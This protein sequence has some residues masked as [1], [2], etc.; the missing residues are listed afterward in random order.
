[1]DDDVILAK[2]Q[3]LLDS[4]S[5]R[6]AHLLIQPLLKASQPDALFLYST[7]SVD[8]NE[9]NEEFERRSIAL[10]TKAS[11]LGHAGATFVL[12]GYYDSGDMVL[13]DKPYA[14][15]LCKRAADAGH[16]TAKLIY[17]LDLFYGANGIPQDKALG[18]RL[19][20]EAAQDGVDGALT[21]LQELHSR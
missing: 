17:G 14:A 11:T 8:R 5:A 3:E 2:A 4:G 18:R 13:M 10:L 19:V 21:R 6:K 16:V 1:M 12:A 9:S 15:Q 20:E 7:Y